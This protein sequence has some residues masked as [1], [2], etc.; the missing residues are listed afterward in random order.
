MPED[1]FSERNR[2]AYDG[3]LANIL[4]YD[5][6]SQQKVSAGIASVDAANCYD[7]VAHSIASLVFQSF[8]VREKP[9]TAMLEAI[10]E[11]QFF[12][13]TSYGDSKDFS[14]STIE[15]KMQ[16]L[17]QGNLCQGNGAAPAGWCVISIT[18][19][20]CQK[21]KGYGAK[22]LSP[23]S[24]VKTDLAAILFI[25]DTNILHLIM[26]KIESIDDTFEGLQDS[27]NN[28]GKLLIA[29]GGARKP[30]KFF[31]ILLDFEWNARGKW[32]YKLHH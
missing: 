25:D 21:S 32:K 19:L 15:L 18:I 5:I 23:I 31:Y 27:V 1:I 13:Q 28:W 7:R 3:G 30:P 14:G 6:V 9:V 24:L 12:P 10:E 22:F 4:F 26:G 29:T 16:G 2:M 17:C 8:G 20:Q 11:M